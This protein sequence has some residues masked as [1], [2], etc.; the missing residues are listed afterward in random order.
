LSFILDSFELKHVPGVTDLPEEGC[1]VPPVLLNEVSLERDLSLESRLGKGRA[2]RTQDGSH[3]ERSER[4]TDK[5]KQGQVKWKIGLST[6]KV[7]EVTP[8]EAIAPGHIYF[9]SFVNLPS[10]QPHFPRDSWY[11]GGETNY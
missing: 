3:L 9:E 4:I 6:D 11:Q 5:L 2:M 7:Q 10:I 8:P 1:S